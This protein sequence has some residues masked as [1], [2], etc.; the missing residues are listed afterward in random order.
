MEMI[1]ETLQVPIKTALQLF[2]IKHTI[3]SNLFLLRQG[4]TWIAVLKYGQIS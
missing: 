3:S 2:D 4:K 1:G